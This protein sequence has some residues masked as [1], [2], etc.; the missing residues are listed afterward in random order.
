[1]I[2]AMETIINIAIDAMSVKGTLFLFF[3]TKELRGMSIHG[4][5]AIANGTLGSQKIARKRSFT[6]TW[7]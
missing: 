1:M 5:T 6:G 2:D 7:R 4:I 3:L